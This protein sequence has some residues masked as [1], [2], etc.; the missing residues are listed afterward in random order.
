MFDF[1]AELCL[2]TQALFLL[3]PQR[4]VKTVNSQISARGPSQAGAWGV[5]AWAVVLV[6]HSLRGS[7]ARD[8]FLEHRS[9][10][11][12]QICPQFSQL[13]FL[14]VCIEG[15]K[16]KKPV[17]QSTCCGANLGPGCCQKSGINEH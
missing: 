16:W 5:W 13:G 4:D 10:Y 8:T 3:S 15:L 11:R 17:C 12:R 1:A 7:D 9:C 14:R 2:N 6:S